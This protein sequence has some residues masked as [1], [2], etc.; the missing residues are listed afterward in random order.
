MW[1]TNSREFL[2]NGSKV[3]EQNAFFFLQLAYNEILWLHLVLK[4][5]NLL[6]QHVLLLMQQLLYLVRFD[7][8]Q[9]HIHIIM[10][11]TVIIIHHVFTGRMLFLT[12]NRMKVLK[13]Q[14]LYKKY[15]VKRC[16]CGYLSEMRCRLFAHHPADATASP[17]PI[18]PCLIYI[19]TGITFLVPAY[20][21]CPAKEAVKWVQ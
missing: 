7:S 5:H 19:H 12:P 6:S 21:G 1:G 2:L 15:W 9:H 10:I 13:A 20:P 8:L 11:I 4:C 14:K 17:N 16:W 18:I 3:A